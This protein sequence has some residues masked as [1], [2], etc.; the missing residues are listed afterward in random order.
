MSKYLKMDD[1]TD[2]A[3][4]LAELHVSRET[5]E[6]LQIYVDLLAKWQSRINLV[7]TQ[8]L[9]TVWRR[10]ILDSLQLLPFLPQTKSR[11]MD[12][13]TGAGLPGLILAI[14]SEHELHLVESDERKC[15]FLRTALRETGTQAQI[16]NQRVESLDDMQID[17]LTARALAPV[18]TL[19]D[20]TRSQHHAGLKCVFLKGRNLNS[21]LTILPDWPTVESHSY[22]SLSS[23]EGQILELVFTS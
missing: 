17:I 23:D 6:R 21:E 18:G 7:S 11:I 14:A 1:A 16:H 15:A 20:W 8:T 5:V 19:L 12:I 10:H 13:G 9:R 3:Q 2:V 22:P 4:E